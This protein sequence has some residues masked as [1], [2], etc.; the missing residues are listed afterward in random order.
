MVHGEAI[1]TRRRDARQ[2]ATMTTDSLSPEPTAPLEFEDLLKDLDAILDAWF[3]GEV[4][5]ALDEARRAREAPSTE[6][7]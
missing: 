7:A 5:P 1:S 3:M 4:T 2:E 6:A